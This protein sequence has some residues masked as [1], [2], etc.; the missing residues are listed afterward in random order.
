[1]PSSCAGLLSYDC[2][3]TAWP[4]ALELAPFGTNFRFPRPH[5]RIS[6][7]LTGTCAAMAGRAE[8]SDSQNPSTGCDLGYLTMCTGFRTVS[9]V[10]MQILGCWE[11]LSTK[12]ALDQAVKVRKVI[13]KRL[14]RWNNKTWLN[15]AWVKSLELFNKH[16]Q[17]VSGVESH[18]Y[19]ELAA[20]KFKGHIETFQLPLWFFK[21]MSFSNMDN[22]NKYHSI[23]VTVLMV[24]ETSKKSAMRKYWCSSH[25]GE[26]F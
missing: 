5:C 6:T 15:Y 9:L 4:A 17:K 14:K 7:R 1:M 8:C 19:D 26:I 20:C 11:S 12:L 24:A 21:Q 3:T 18:H 22:N 13:T 25:Y 10:S 16:L 23:L 2:S